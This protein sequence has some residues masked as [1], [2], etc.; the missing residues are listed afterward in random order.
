MKSIGILPVRVNSFS[1]LIIFQLFI[2]SPWIFFFFKVL[3]VLYWHIAD[4]WVVVVVKNLSANV[5]GIETQV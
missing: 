1:P 2:Y 5:G 4:S 3:F